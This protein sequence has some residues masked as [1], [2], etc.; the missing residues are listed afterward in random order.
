MSPRIGKQA[1]S[2]RAPPP[3]T[4]I[5]PTTFV[6]GGLH[7]S[8]ATCDRW[9]CAHA[10]PFELEGVGCSS[11]PSQRRNPKC[12]PD[13]LRQLEEAFSPLHF[14]A[15]APSSCEHH[16][17]TPSL[18]C[19]CAPLRC[20][21]G[22]TGAVASHGMYSAL[23]ASESSS[24]RKQK[25]HHDPCSVPSASRSA[26]GARCGPCPV[27]RRKGHIR[28]TPKSQPCPFARRGCSL[29][30]RHQVSCIAQGSNRLGP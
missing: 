26:Q 13:H 20:K 6:V 4:P 5:C 21:S 11:S 10:N 9:R 14:E 25:C 8:G 1:S 3:N 23:R 28:G 12:A 7:R 18:G 24:T 17:P 15:Q 19:G 30:A 2:F 22:R 29:W 16:C 27:V